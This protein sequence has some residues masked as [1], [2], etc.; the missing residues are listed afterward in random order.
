MFRRKRTIILSTLL[1]SALTACGAGRDETSTKPTTT[2]T[3]WG[4]SFVYE[5]LTETVTTTVQPTP[6]Q[7]QYFKSTEPKD[8]A[9]ASSDGKHGSVNRDPSRTCPADET[10]R[11]GQSCGKAKSPLIDGFDGR[12]VLARTNDVNCKEALGVVNRYLA[13]PIDGQHGNRN[14]RS[15]GTWTCSMPSAGDIVRFGW[16]LSCADNRPTKNHKRLPAVGIKTIQ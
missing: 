12:S 15:F 7:D 8:V 5:T 14:L 16:E 13:T 1:V 10:T 9:D 3:K 11:I 4:T 6:P 2:I